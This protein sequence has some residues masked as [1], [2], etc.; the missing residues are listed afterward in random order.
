MKKIFN[1]IIILFFLLSCTVSTTKKITSGTSLEKKSTAN[2]T[3][4]V[5]TKVGVCS[6][7]D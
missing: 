5:S 3:F 4:N 6:N 2:A 1:L 7:C